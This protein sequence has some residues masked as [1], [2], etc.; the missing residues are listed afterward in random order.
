MAQK[1]NRIP[2]ILDTDIGGDIDDTW[3]LAMLLNSPEL[4]VK[5]I[6]TATADT[7]YRA[8]I[9]ARILQRARRTGIPIG[10]GP[11]FESDGPRERQRDWVNGY[12]LSEYPGIIYENGVQGIIDAIESS[13]EPV[14][15][16]AIG[17]A[18]NI[19]ELLERRPAVANRVNLVGMFGSIH[20][21]HK[22]RSGAIAEF[23][24]LQDI[25]A[26]QKVFSA[27]WKSVTITP[28]DTCGTVQLTGELYAQLLASNDPLLADVLE[29][30]R[31]W[32]R[33]VGSQFDAGRRSSILYDTVAIHLAYSNRYL[34]M[35]E[36]GLRVSNDGYT[37]IDQSA[38]PVNVAVDW[39]DYAGF[40]MEL[41]NRLLGE[42]K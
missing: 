19:A 31:I 42:N 21:Q 23:N 22:G 12:E 18:T 36:M 29:N 35:K 30:Y 8:R 9:C 7:V 1:S 33:A 20:R 13:D 17:P 38:R 34:K 37:V 28:L 14:T 3:A 4:D 39:L 27:P 24:V 25:T 40:C 5:L 15:L 10:I 11:R 2:V 16:I 26:C 6:T 41:T 32:N